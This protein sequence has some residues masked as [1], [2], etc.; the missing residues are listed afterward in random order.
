M[1]TSE[2]D[3][4]RPSLTVDI[5]VLRFVRRTLKV[6]LIE[7]KS[8]PFQ[9]RFALPGGFVDEHEAPIDAAKRELLE[10]THVAGLPLVDI[11]TFGQA[12]RDP[13][14][15]VVS[16]AFM[17]FV[18]SNIEA[19][20]GD[21]AASVEWHPLS[22]LPP[23]AFDHADILLTAQERLKELSVTSTLA[24]TLLGDSFRTAEARQLYSQIWNV[25][26]EPRRFKAWLRRRQAVER[27]GPGR[28]QAQSELSLDC[29][30]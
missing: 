14:G 5:V 28:F 21:D 7:R 3:Y 23:M 10:E 9:G 20:A 4:P 8:D 22:N 27:V 12:G 1:S 30:K 16:T 6:L 19:H 26:I 15:W 11:G 24:L 25:P 13:R 2:H 29:L 18:P 17:G